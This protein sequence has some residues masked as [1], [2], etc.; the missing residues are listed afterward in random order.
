MKEYI[1]REGVLSYID[2]IGS[3]GAGKKKSL[4]FIRK[5]LENM[6]V[7]QGVSWIPIT[8][9]MPDPD[10][11]EEI[12]VTLDWGDIKE[13][14]NMDYAFMRK[15]A[16]DGNSSAQDLLDHITAWT[17]SIDPYQRPDTE[18]DNDGE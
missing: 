18:N 6:P 15:A 4:E 9:R 13:V 10:D 2:W 8:E 3:I 17:P 16:D 5:Y 11:D 14:V 1:S 12:V 7:L